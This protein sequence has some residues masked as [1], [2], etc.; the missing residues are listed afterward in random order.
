MMARPAGAWSVLHVMRVPVGRAGER[1]RA[2]AAWTERRA[3]AAWALALLL[4]LL[5]VG[6]HASYWARNDYP[7]AWFHDPANHQRDDLAVVRAAAG[8]ATN[9]DL[10]SY[11]F[12]SQIDHVGWYRPIPSTLW[13]CEYRL[14]G[15]DDRRWNLVS[16]GLYLLACV[17]LVWMAAAFWDGPRWQRLLV[18]AAGIL[19]FGG[20][21]LADR[22]L[23]WWMLT[24]WPA[25]PDLLSLLFGALLLGAAARHYHTGARAWAT[26]APV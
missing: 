4:V 12:S 6:W 1:L 23:Q 10:A 20:P 11:W 9:E 15:P 16:L 13:V 8:A 24:W 25:Q 7:G 14:L 22:D 17:A 19:L 21:G 3:A 26:A 5:P 2:L 18:A